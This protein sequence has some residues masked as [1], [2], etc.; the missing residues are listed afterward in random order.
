M[1]YLY[2][3]ILLHEM[4]ENFYAMIVVTY[5]PEMKLSKH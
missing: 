3:V 4:S 5:V 1:I 2:P